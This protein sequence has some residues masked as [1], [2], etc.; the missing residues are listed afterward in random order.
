MSEPYIGEIRMVGFN[1]APRGWALCDGQ[2]V[3]ISQN[4]ALFSVLG[5]SY[6]G[7]GST[8]F[9]LPDMRGRIPIHQGQGPGLSPRPL[10]QKSGAEN[11]SLTQAEIP[12]HEHSG[13]QAQDV[14]AHSHLAAN[15]MI[16]DS[17]REPLFTEPTDLIEVPGG[18]VQNAG[19]SQSHNN[20]MPAAVIH[21]VI[22]LV[23]IYPARS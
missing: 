16:A 5:T 17:G 20:M 6:G 7:N 23:G 8:T 4:D 15:N 13:L 14:T 18:T 1:F 11:V 10:G 12:A 2:L 9:S 22:A 21:F 3:S 19:G